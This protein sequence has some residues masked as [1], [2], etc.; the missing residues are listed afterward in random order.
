MNPKKYQ[1]QSLD[2]L[3]YWLGQLK[4]YRSKD[5]IDNS[6]AINLAWGKVTE[7]YKDQS[8]TSSQKRLDS[9]GIEFPHACIKIPTGG[10]KTFI[11]SQSITRI[12]RKV[13]G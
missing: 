10:G 5:G 1:R 9:G 7:K 12:M 6:Q 2:A 8:S 3:E 4:I 13:K 11:A